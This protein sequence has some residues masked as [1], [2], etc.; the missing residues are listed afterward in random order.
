MWSG[1]V[2]RGDFGCGCDLSRSGAGVAVDG[3]LLRFTFAIPRGEPG[4]AGP[5]ESQGEVSSMDLSN[6]IRAQRDQQPRRRVRRC[7]QRSPPQ[8]EVQAIA[9]KL[10][11]LSLALR[12]T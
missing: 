9:D 5:Q 7:H 3:N 12:R 2:T 1:W 8:M 6:V 4:Q 11:D 10:D